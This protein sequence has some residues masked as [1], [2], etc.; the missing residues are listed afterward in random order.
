MGSTTV[1]A[2]AEKKSVS[3]YDFYGDI[4][5]LSILLVSG[6]A[7]VFRRAVNQHVAFQAP[8]SG[9]EQ[10][11]GYQSRRGAAEYQPSRIDLASKDEHARD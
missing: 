9:C 10:L 5:R 2:A 8:A 4:R 6:A 1:N 11:V 3:A 7:F